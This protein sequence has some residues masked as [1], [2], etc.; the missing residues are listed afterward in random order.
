MDLRIVTVAERLTVKSSFVNEENEPW[1]AFMNA[2]VFS[3]AGRNMT[4]NA[5]FR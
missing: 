5:W 4:G 2:I 1:P 3:P